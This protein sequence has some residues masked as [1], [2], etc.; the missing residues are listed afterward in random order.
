MTPK[1]KTKKTLV[2]LAMVLIPCFF[3]FGIQLPVDDISNPESSGLLDIIAKKDGTWNPTLIENRYRKDE[4]SA[5]GDFLQWWYYTLFNSQTHESW[6][7]CYYILFSVTPNVPSGLMFLFSYVSPQGNVQVS[8]ELDLSEMEYEGNYCQFD[9]GNGMFQHIPISDNV[10]HITGLMNNPTKLWSYYITNPSFNENMTFSWDVTLTRLVGCFSQNDELLEASPS[11]NSQAFDTLVNGQIVMNNRIINVGGNSWRGYGDMNWGDKFMTSSLDPENPA[12]YRWGW[13][14]VTQMNADP[15]KDFALISAFGDIDNFA[16]LQID[17]RAVY[18]SV[19][20]GI[21]TQDINW[22]SV[23]MYPLGIETNVIE[24]CSWGSSLDPWNEC[25][26]SATNFIEYTDRFGSAIV[27]SLQTLILEGEYIKI[28][29]NVE[30]GTEDITRLL[31][32]TP[33]GVWS[34]FEALGATANVQ[35]QQKSYKWYDP[36]HTCP[37][38]TTIKSFIDNNAGLEFGYPVTIDF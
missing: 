38:Y 13:I 32:P 4:F 3:I 14:H 5:E 24:E 27:P 21:G 19:S 10:Y 6:A 8:Y 34:N 37:I 1:E 28:T 23:K 25:D 36:L 17:T 20:N 35:V 16:G 31:T 18:A 2:V 26:Y 11:W 33:S 12:K 7:F 22:K 29:V 15:N 30:V 9:F